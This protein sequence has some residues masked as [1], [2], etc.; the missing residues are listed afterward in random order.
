MIRNYLKFPIVSG[1]LVIGSLFL[2]PAGVVAQYAV[3]VQVPANVAWTDTGIT[4]KVGD[5]LEIRALGSWSFDPKGSG[6]HSPDGDRK[7]KRSGAGFPLPAQPPGILLAKAGNQVRPIGDSAEMKVLEN[8]QLF[9]GINDA[10]IEDNQGTLSVTITAKGGRTLRT[11]TGQNATTQTTSATRNVTLH[12]QD[13]RGNP[14]VGYWV[15]VH[16]APEL[17]G[18]KMGKEQSD[19]QGNYT[20]SLP[21]GKYRVSIYDGDKLVWDEGFLVPATRGPANDI[22]ITVK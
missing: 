19:R 15:S 1:L 13:T 21:D 5:V 17:G 10:G 22:T 7:V 14:L 8:G 18:Q 12:I 3:T 16:T 2:H 11:I 4:V 20:I 9:L 6:M